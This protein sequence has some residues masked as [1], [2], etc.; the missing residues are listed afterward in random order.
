MYG[1]GTKPVPLCSFL[2]DMSEI[3]ERHHY[4]YCPI[5]NFNGTDT[6]ELY[7]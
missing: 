6:Q 7:L 4:S 2:S 5:K 1:T 3:R